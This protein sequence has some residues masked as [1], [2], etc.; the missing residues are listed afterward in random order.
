MNKIKSLSISFWFKELKFNPIDKINKL[1]EYLGNDYLKP[2][3]NNMDINSNLSIPRYQFISKDNKNIFMG[4]LINCNLIFNFKEEMDYNDVILLANSNMQLYYD[5]I[6]EVYDIDIKYTSLKIEMVNDND[7]IINSFVKNNNLPNNDYEDLSL[8]KVIAKDNTYYLSYIENT[9]KEVQ[10]NYVIDNNNKPSEQDLFD[11]S[12]VMSLSEATS[13]KEFLF[14]IIE[15]NDRLA[16]NLDKD[17]NTTKENIRGMISE[18]KS[19]LE[20]EINEY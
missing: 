1:E 20:K 2:L 19:F 10:Y 12:M 7:D 4:T 16:Y 14:T 8:K 3:I 9:G 17:Y 11:R 6:K 18:L 15:I 13:K 5:M